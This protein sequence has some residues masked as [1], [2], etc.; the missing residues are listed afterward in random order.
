MAKIIDQIIKDKN[1]GMTFGVVL[2]GRLFKINKNYEYTRKEK[3][4]PRRI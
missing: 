2:K 4:T 1:E 3:N